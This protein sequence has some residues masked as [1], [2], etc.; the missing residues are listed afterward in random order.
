MKIAVH[1][2]L[3]PF[4][5]QFRGVEV[6]PIPSPL[7]LLQGQGQQSSNTPVCASKSDTL[8]LLC[9]GTVATFLHP[10]VA[11]LHSALTISRAS[12]QFKA[13]SVISSGGN[14]TVISLIN[15]RFERVMV[16]AANAVVLLVKRGVMLDS[17]WGI[18]AM[19][20]TLAVFDGTRFINNTAIMLGGALI[21]MGGHAHFSECVFPTG[22]Q[23]WMKPLAGLALLQ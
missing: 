3:A 23:Q 17:M 20:V 5:P 9:N 22:L 4:V 21:V 6:A 1:P 18:M 15:P 16:Q 19:G 2:M 11:N 7:Q 8:L 10:R 13:I 12:P 14:D